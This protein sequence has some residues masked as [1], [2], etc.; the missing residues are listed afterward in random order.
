MEFALAPCAWRITTRNF[1]SAIIP[2][3]H[4]A[5]AII[6]FGNRALEAAVVH[7]MIFDF[8]REAA[9]TSFRWKA[10]RHGPGLENAFHFQTKIVMQSRRG[11]FLNHER[12]LAGGALFY[13]SRRLG[14]AGEVAFGF[15]LF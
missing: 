5:R 2:K 1:I 12:E 3:H 6:A 10:L 8:D 11:V 9:V 15:V 14:G 4:C 13:F 7:G